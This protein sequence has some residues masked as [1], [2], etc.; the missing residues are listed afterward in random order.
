MGQKRKSKETLKE[1][2]LTKMR[3]YEIQSS[4]L[5]MLDMGRLYLVTKETVKK[6]YEGKLKNEPKSFWKYYK[7]SINDDLERLLINLQ[8]QQVQ[9]EEWPSL[10][11]ELVNSFFTPKLTNKELKL[12]EKAD[13]D[14][15][16]TY[17]KYLLLDNNPDVDIDEMKRSDSKSK[18]VHANC[19]RYTT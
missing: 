13:E 15:L 1:I 9:K 12:V 5:T 16:K 17:S 10:G 14:H 3:K 4:I 2:I 11:P 19:V 18:Y 8:N 6:A 7:G